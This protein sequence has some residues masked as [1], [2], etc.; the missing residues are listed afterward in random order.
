MLDI[1]SRIVRLQVEQREVVLA[2]LVS[3]RGSSARDPGA[4]FAVSDG[5][6][7]V[8]AVGGG[9]VEAAL[10]EEAREVM[11]DGKARSIAYDLSDSEAMDIGL[12][13][14]GA[15]TILLDRLDPGYCAELE[16]TR[17]DLLAH[18]LRLDGDA[19]GAR[20]AI[21]PERCHGTLGDAGI[22]AAVA[23]VVRDSTLHAA[24]QIDLEGA[25]VFIAP[26]RIAPH[27]YVFGALDFAAATIDTAHL[28]GYV[29]TLCDA[30]SAFATKARF[31]NADRIVVAWPQEFLASAPIDER[32]AILS[33]THDEKFDVPL[34]LTAVRSRAGYV[35][36]VGSRATHARRSEALRKAGMSE[37]E[38]ARI[39]A[40]IGLDIGARTPEETAL[41][42]LAEIVAVERGRSGGSLS[43]GTGAIRGRIGA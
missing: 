40:P 36:A 35:G 38:L 22:D 19:I 30:R 6:E 37:A 11:R 27:M 32:T 8:G 3:V 4:A 33:F 41:A 10:V 18:A 13:C 1:L 23:K 26:K 14:G 20:M 21:Y 9:C 15:L 17:D 24:A 39:C 28:L 31:P 29:V 2:T 43:R 7:L 12:A 42:V 16:R 25:S 34:L 5:G